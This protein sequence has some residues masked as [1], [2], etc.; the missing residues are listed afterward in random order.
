MVDGTDALAYVV[1]RAGRRPGSIA[2]E[3][4]ARGL[5]KPQAAYV[6]RNVAA[7]WSMDLPIQGN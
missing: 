5:T 6:L 2:V 4:S 1:I 3:A 7:Q